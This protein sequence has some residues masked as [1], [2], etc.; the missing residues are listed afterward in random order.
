MLFLALCTSYTALALRLSWKQALHLRGYGPV[1]SQWERHARAPLA[2]LASLIT[3]NNNNSA[4]ERALPF[5]QT[6]SLRLFQFS[7]VFKSCVIT[8][9][10]KELCVACTELLCCSV[11]L[12]LLLSLPSS[13]SSSQ[14]PTLSDSILNLGRIS[15]QFG[16]FANFK[17]L[18]PAV[19]TDFAKEKFAAAFGIYRCHNHI[20]V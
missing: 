12:Y 14:L 15:F 1:R 8:L 5:F 20:K 10:Q 18:F 3:W 7:S 2:E 16:R 13:A 4:V 19:P 6:N 17:A 11:N 9:V